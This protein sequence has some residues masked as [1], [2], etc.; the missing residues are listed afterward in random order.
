MLCSSL[1]RQI[2]MQRIRFWEAALNVDPQ[3]RRPLQTT[4]SK[5]LKQEYAG[6]Q[7]EQCCQC[8]RFLGISIKRK[9]C[10]VIRSN[11]IESKDVGNCERWE[12]VLTTHHSVL[13]HLAS[14]HE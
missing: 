10:N 2:P 4:V 8:I 3:H 11:C 9:A 13:C 5:Y 1:L 7:K 6:S 12:I 14:L